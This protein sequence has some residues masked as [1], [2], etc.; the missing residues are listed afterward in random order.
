MLEHFG[1]LVIDSGEDGPS[2]RFLRRC[3]RLL[4]CSSAM[5]RVLAKDGLAPP[6][7][8]QLRDASAGPASE[9]AKAATEH[10]EDT[11]VV[12]LVSGLMRAVRVEDACRF[13]VR[14]RTQRFAE[15]LAVLRRDTPMTPDRGVQRAL[16]WDPML[17]MAGSTALDA[18]PPR[19]VLQGWCAEARR[20]LD[21][22]MSLGQQRELDALDVISEGE[23]AAGGSVTQMSDSDTDENQH[24]ATS[25]AGAV[26]S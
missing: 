19:K 23:E 20:G 18:S 9:R 15:L 12:E 7:E 22:I 1:V 13:I 17:A 4:K 21:G 10:A 24:E 8:E 6:L 26:L 3:T 11:A 14:R 5:L 16:Q 25:R 2:R